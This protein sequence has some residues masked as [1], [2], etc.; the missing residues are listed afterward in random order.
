MKGHK[1][2]EFIFK[3]LYYIKHVAV[4]NSYSRRPLYLVLKRKPAGLLKKKNQKSYRQA[5]Y[6]PK[7]PAA[8]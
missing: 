1:Q 4:L 3:F 5:L 6:T 8:L 7:N 2:T